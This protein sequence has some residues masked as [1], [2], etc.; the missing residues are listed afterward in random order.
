M[1]KKIKAVIWDL[2]GTLIDFKINSIGARRKAIKILRNH[3]IPK[4]ELSIQ[5]SIL[6][7]V[8]NSQILFTE[9]GIPSEETQRIIAEINNAVIAVE[10][11]AALKATLTKGIGA[12]LEFLKKSKIKQAIFTY[13]THANA[14]LSLETAG[15]VSYFEIIVGRDDIR[16]LKPHPDHV[17]K[18]C[19]LLGVEFDEVLIIGDTNTDIEAA[20]NVGSYSIALNTNIPKFIKRDAF[21]KANEIIDVK[22]IPNALIKAIQEFM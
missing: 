10:R 22:T 15:I 12:V 3:G 11:Q 18:I 6:E 19:E 13:N 20:L 4:N 14:V 7:N 5:K 2:D 8:K 17:K 16:N 21:Q 1:K 9:Y